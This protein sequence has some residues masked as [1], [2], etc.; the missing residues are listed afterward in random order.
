MRLTELI[1]AHLT[2]S[3]G[4]EV[5]DPDAIQCGVLVPVLPVDGG[6]GLVYTLRSEHLPSHKGQVSFPG[7]KRSDD[8]DD[9]LATALRE[10]KE[11]VGIEPGDV[12]VL[13]RL[14]A[15][16]TMATEFI[17]TPF[18]GL[19]PRESRFMLDPGEVSELFTVTFDDLMDPAH[20]GTDTKSWRGSE[21]EVAAITAG[22]H[23]IWGATHQITTNFLAV[24]EQLIGERPAR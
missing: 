2:E 23:N 14:D 9:V 3:P 24:L 7:G 13:G 21:F 1:Q 4:I 20:H 12:E 22:P 17:I 11:E 6:Y 5:D 16:H 10:T 15:V 19:L 18:V 8:D